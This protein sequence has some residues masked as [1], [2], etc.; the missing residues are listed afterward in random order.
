[1][2]FYSKISEENKQTMI[3]Q[4]I[5]AAKNQINTSNSDENLS[6]SQNYL[7]TLKANVDIFKV[8]LN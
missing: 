5:E 2:S 6:I 4:T 8:L 3:S 1:M 7:Q